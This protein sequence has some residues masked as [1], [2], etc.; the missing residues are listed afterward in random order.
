MNYEEITIGIRAEKMIC[1][2]NSFFV[3]SDIVEMCGGERNVYFVL[4]GSSCV[5]KVP[6]DYHFSDKIELKLSVVNMYFFDKT[7][8]MN[9]FYR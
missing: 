2:S 3:N 9:I 1:G 7:T 6:L 8:G 4:N 5:A